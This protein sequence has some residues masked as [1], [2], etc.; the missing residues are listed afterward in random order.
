MTENP[1]LNAIAE[2]ESNG[3][4]TRPWAEAGRLLAICERC[5]KW[6]KYGCHDVDVRPGPFALFLCDAS[7]TCKRWGQG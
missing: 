4:A 2:M 7:R 1:L 3:L 5:P 6:D